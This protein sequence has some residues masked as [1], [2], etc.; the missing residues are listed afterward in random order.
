MRRRAI[1]LFLI[2]FL[3]ASFLASISFFVLPVHANGITRVQGNARGTGTSSP[4][5]VTIGSTPT[6]GNVLVAVISSGSS[7]AYRTVSSIT[8]TNVVWTY[9]I[10][11]Q[12]YEFSYMQVEIW[13]GVVSASAST[14][15][16]VAFSGSMNKG[17]VVDICEY[18]GVATSS[19]LDQTATSGGRNSP[20]NTGTTATTT[21]ANELW[22]GGISWYYI[23]KQS[24]PTNGFAML[25]GDV[26]TQGSCA[27]L[28]K[29]VSATAT[30]NSGTS[31]ADNEGWAGAIATFKASAETTPPTYSSIASNA[32]LRNTA[33]NCS[34]TWTDETNI[35]G[36][37]FGCNFTGSWVNQTWTSS[38]TV[39][40]TTKSARYDYLTTLGT[41]VGA[42]DQWEMWCN[43]TSNNWN[44]TGVQTITTTA[45]VQTDTFT[46]SPTLS[47]S[48]GS[49][50]GLGLVLS[51]LSTL[52]S[53]LQS[54]YA[55]SRVLSSLAQMTS[56]STSDYSL[57]LLLSSLP[58]L[59]ATLQSNTEI[60]TVLSSLSSLSSS[61]YSNA[62]IKTLLLSLA[63]MS[64]AS[65][66]TDEFIAFL[67]SLSSLVSS[68][69]S[70][71]AFS[72]D[73]SSLATL[74][75]S[76]TSNYEFLV[77]FGANPS[78]S[79]S[80]V[81]LLNV[82]GVK[83]LLYIYTSLATLSSTESNNY[84]LRNVLSS[85]SNLSSSSGSN[86]ALSS[87][88]L[89]LS[90]L[91]SS[92]QSNYEFMIIPLSL[93]SISSNSKT[94]QE[95]FKQLSS[96]ASKISSTKVL[97]EFLTGLFSTSSESSLLSQ[98]SVSRLGIFTSIMQAISLSKVGQELMVNLPSTATISSTADIPLKTIV[99][100]ILG[101]GTLMVN[102]VYVANGTGWVYN[103]GKTYT[104]AAFPLL[105]Q[106]IFQ[107]Y[108]FNNVT[109][110]YDPLGFLPFSPGIVYVNF[111]PVSIPAPPVGPI[112]P[113]VIYAVS[114]M[115]L[116]LIPV[117]TSLSFYFWQ[118]TVDFNVVVVNK[119]TQATDVA[120]KWEMYDS[121]NNTV[122][123][124]TQ[125]LFIS[126]L[127]EK[128]VVIAI[129]VHG[130]TY[131]MQVQ[132]TSP[133]QIQVTQSL[134]MAG[135]FILGSLV[136]SVGLLIVIL[137]IVVALALR[138]RRR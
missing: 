103:P 6:S 65:T 116:D 72:T 67:S 115:Q 41:L 48:S 50:Y 77:I 46:S 133:L 97:Q 122:A 93:S 111:V 20:S 38:W 33:V 55:F 109:Y 14:S 123:L 89:S 81:L 52:S 134:T 120:L 57:T 114:P 82:S 95:F 5:A 71:Y 58:N 84:E 53:S 79:S 91:N 112:A 8:E 135:V 2:V 83:S 127:D 60:R 70:N 90:I 26:Y 19:F 27:Y 7:T 100:Q 16:S 138:K 113:T 43:D 64:S 80:C 126:G 34:V 88:L 128:H 61:S 12:H 118:N 40:L 15:V 21:L 68:S 18:S 51:S 121:H 129:P 1:T 108:M 66:S 94:S 13:V 62:E 124:G 9:Q 31:G 132:T 117:T 87:L 85:L 106:T 102:W 92:S 3:L 44:N 99:F 101:N 25:D 125:T 45:Y 35:S 78:V 39:W 47:S 137:F 86:I 37:I 131:T 119:G 136:E 17:G 96:N 42:A 36:V 104:L 107:Y 98:A 4:I 30:A 29:I 105:G 110:P 11:S 76:S 69:E 54:N 28:E 32:T 74:S 10:R 49:N 59:N 22:I 75:S 63:N 23:T 56:S 130:G 24:S 73:F